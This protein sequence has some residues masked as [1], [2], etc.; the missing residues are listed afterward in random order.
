MKSAAFSHAK[1]FFVYA[2][3]MQP[4]LHITEQ[5]RCF[6]NTK[7]VFKTCFKAECDTLIQNAMFIS[8]YYWSFKNKPKNTF[9]PVFCPLFSG[10]F[11][12]AYPPPPVLSPR[13][14]AAFAHKFFIFQFFLLFFLP[15]ILNFLFILYFCI[16]SFFLNPFLFFSCFSGWGFYILGV[17]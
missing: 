4:I 14:K 10:G 17:S 13:L 3:L 16:P 8:S 2:C 9:I 15:L 6:Q 1:H 7:R 12:R 5:K 11:P